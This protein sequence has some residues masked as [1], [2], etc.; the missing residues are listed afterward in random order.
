MYIVNPDE[1]LNKTKDREFQLNG[2]RIHTNLGGLKEGLDRK[3]PN[4][5]RFTARNFFRRVPGKYEMSENKTVKLLDINGKNITKERL[6]TSLMRNDGRLLKSMKE[7]KIDSYCNLQK[8]LH[9]NA[10]FHDLQKYFRKRL[11]ERAEDVLLDC[12]DSDDRQLKLRA[13]TFILETL[14]KDSGY[15]KN[16]PALINVD[17]RN[18]PDELQNKI[19]NIFQIKTEEYKPQEINYDNIPVLSCETVVEE[20]NNIN[21]EVS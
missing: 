9:T 18:N 19:K 13:A 17:L 15:S 12:L 3:N 1:E 6:M 2:R 20:E 7:L 14:G 16:Q 5:A 4:E 10:E 21:E 8:F 11:C